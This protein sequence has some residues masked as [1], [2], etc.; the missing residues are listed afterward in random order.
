VTP[1]PDDTVPEPII[2]AF[3][4]SA[5]YC[6]A[7][8]LRGKSLLGLQSEDMGRGQAERLVPMLD[9]L[10]KGADLDWSD[11]DALAVGVGPGN[12]T[13]I[14]IAVSTARGLALALDIPAIGVS[15][16]QAISKTATLPHLAC[17]P[18]PQ[19]QVYIAPAGTDPR[20]V[21][22][23]EAHGLGLPLALPPAPADLVV[24][25]ARVARARLRKGDTLQAPAPLYVRAAD[26]APSR[27]TPP[28]MLPDDRT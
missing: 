9:D 27:D 11:L 8:L 5:A 2:L 22:M 10:I 15:T 20:L 14:R 17:V 25:M 24:A 26:A 21:S 6:A 18:A 13:G 23:D 19:S 16:F 1:Q 12:F 3:D 28:V 7:A 4:T